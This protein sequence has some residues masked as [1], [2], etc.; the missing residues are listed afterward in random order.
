[1]ISK[2]KRLGF[3]FHALV[4]L[5][6]GPTAKIAA[7]PC[8]DSF[9][10]LRSREALLR[11]QLGVRVIIYLFVRISKQPRNFRYPKPRKLSESSSRKNFCI[12]EFR[13]TNSNSRIF[14]NDFNCPIV[15]ICNDVTVCYTENII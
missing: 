3:N 14:R 6:F 7:Q 13:L 12:F 4:G 2:I 9:K 10:L 8:Q 11:W 1:M 5:Q 15:T